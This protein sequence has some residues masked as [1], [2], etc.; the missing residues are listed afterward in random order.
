MR[1]RDDVGIVPYIHVE[2][3]AI[4]RIPPLCGG[5]VFSA[6]AMMQKTSASVKTILF[7]SALLCYTIGEKKSKKD[8]SERN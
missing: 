5:I 8:R 1:S 2:P 3:R 4:Q 7:I 6:A